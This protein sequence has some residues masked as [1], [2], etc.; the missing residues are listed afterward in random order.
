MKT[1]LI[2]ALLLVLGY[3][4]AVGLLAWKQRRLIYV[5]DKDHP[6]LPAAG[7]ANVKEI[8][9]HTEDGLD[10]L[11]WLASPS[12]G[13]QPVVLYLHG[14]AGNI[15]DRASRFIQLA[16]FGWGVLMPEYRG[17]GGNPGTPTETGLYIDA[18]AAY[19]ALRQRGIPASHIVLW[20][21]SLGSGVATHLASEMATGA[22]LLE[23]PYTSIADIARQR[24]PFIPVDWLLRDRFELL[25]YI[26]K[27]Q[28]PVPPAMSQA[29]FEAANE[30]KMIWLAPDAGHNDLTAAG[31][32]DVV[33]AFIRK[34]WNATP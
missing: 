28:A 19:R 25:R 10:L 2:V 13:A 7:F 12:N 16:R 5:P 23:S 15:G 31:A 6:S 8:T 17:F 11:A 32:F 26:G 27:V 21:E 14:N 18:Q 33:T 20:G 22:V 24:Y 1:I 3:C 30:P 34:H 4:I 29:V 9:I